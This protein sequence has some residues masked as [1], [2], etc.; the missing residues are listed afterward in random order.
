MSKIYYETLHANIPQFSVNCFEEDNKVR[1]IST[2]MHLHREIEMMRV[3]RGK[4][5][6]RILEREEEYILSEGDIIFVN[7]SIPHETESLID[8]TRVEIIQFNPH[9]IV[10][11][12]GKSFSKYISAFLNI[13]NEAVRVFDKHSN[14]ELSRCFDNISYEYKN[15]QSGFEFNLLGNLYLVLG[16]LFK[17]GTILPFFADDEKL[18]EF[19]CIF[20]YI[21]QNFMNKVTMEEI[22]KSNYI[23]PSHFCRIFKKATGKTFVQY[24]NFRRAYEA[25]KLLFKTD[26][27]VTEIAHAVGFSTASYFD[28]IFRKYYLISPTKYR[29]VKKQQGENVE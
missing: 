19:S 13:R 20:E 26:M 12:M 28:K 6:Y 14:A 10:G 29:K 11:E 8:D 16:Q 22:C 27:S 21:E 9:T 1:N 23:S 25:E 2:S 7:V 17:S 3:S 15:K 18:S 24:L 4:V 5:L